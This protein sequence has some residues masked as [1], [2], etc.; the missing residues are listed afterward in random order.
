MKYLF[1][2][3]EIKL[4]RIIWIGNAFLIVSAI[5]YVLFK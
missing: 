2:Q 1:E 4:P 3:K 5:Y